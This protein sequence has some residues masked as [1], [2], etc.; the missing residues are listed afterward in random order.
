MLNCRACLWRCIQ[1]RHVL[2]ANVSNVNLFTHGQRR[3]RTDA[4]E[5][6]QR[7]AQKNGP[8][9][10]AAEANTRREA[11]SPSSPTYVQDSFKTSAFAAN[12]KKRE[13]A[14]M[15]E[16]PA[17]YETPN[18]AK[19]GPRDPR[20]SD[21]DWNRRKMELRHLQDPLD[22]ATFVKQEL[23]KG[24]EDEM[25]QLVRMACHSMQCVVSWNHIIDHKLANGRVNDA[26]KIYNEM[27]KRGQFPDSYTYTI[28]LRGLSTN[29]QTSGVVERALTVYHSLYAPNSRVEPSIIHTNAAL[30]VC[31]RAGNMDALWGIAGKIP[32]S[33]P[34]AANEV[35]YLTIL[36]AIRQNLIID[37]PKG[38]SEEETAARKERGI[39]EGRRMWEDIVG[40]WRRA[41]LFIDEELVCAMGRLLLVGSRPRDWDDVLSL[42]EQTMDIPRLVPRLGSAGRVEAGL[43]RL[44]APN[45]P[46]EY[47]F[48]DDHLSPDKAPARGD[49]F[50]ALTPRGVGAVVPNP[51]V[52]AKPGNNTLSLIQE[53]CQKIVA[54]KAALEYWEL[55]TDPNTYKVEADFNNLTM[56]LRILRQNRASSEAVE[57]LQRNMLDKGFT[58][59]AGTFRIAMSTCVRDK[60]NHNSLKNAG[61]I[62]QIMTK[63][64]E[65]ADS[66]AV[67][68]YADL[69]TSFPLAK[70]SD[71]IDALTLLHP[72]CKNI[73]LQLGVGGGEKESSRFSSPQPL[74]GE[75]KQDA[76][77]ALRRIH[78]VYDKLIH[79]NLIAEEAKSPFKAERARLSSFI[80]RV[81]F[82]DSRIEKGWDPPEEEEYRRKHMQR[83]DGYRGGSAEEADGRRYVQR[84]DRHRDGPAD[85]MGETS[86]NRNNKPAW[87]NEWARQVERSERRFMYS[88]QVTNARRAARDM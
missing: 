46:Q 24:K 34:A 64:L 14:A 9:A 42:I 50:L 45:V 60:N 40:R 70:G 76:V 2:P 5:Y 52:Y 3:L 72:I 28:I 22:L 43:P 30:G 44:R 66:K 19:L 54:N 39:M 57:L 68:M 63:V 11:E 29:A 4:G 78:G 8:W 6:K 49:E 86:R 67:T 23:A 55:L 35:T 61:R 18:L 82:K 21:S 26:F 69:A 58:P 62:L 20:M 38:E 59:R 77:A 88:P 84:E 37:A 73:R 36:N 83:E 17:R 51:L 25:L 10:A 56:R 81:R 1:P 41:D 74:K 16:T 48:D 32:E 15:R 85:E 47:R 7:I 71:L 79:S 12:R 87:K 13:I 75:E 80:Q 31:A 27:K 53:T 33:G 65:D